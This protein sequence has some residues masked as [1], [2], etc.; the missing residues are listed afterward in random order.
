MPGNAVSGPTVGLSFLLHDH[1][2]KVQLSYAHYD[3]APK[4]EDLMTLSC[5]VTF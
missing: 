5:Q 4:D 2:A 1:N 3:V